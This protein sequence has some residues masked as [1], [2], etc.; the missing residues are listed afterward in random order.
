MECNGGSACLRMSR[1]THRVWL[2][3]MD[4]H[5]KVICST[6]LSKLNWRLRR[7]RKYSRHIHLCTSL[8]QIEIKS[9]ICAPGHCGCTLRVNHTGMVPATKS[10]LRSTRDMQYANHHN[11]RRQ[12]TLFYELNS[13]R[14]ISD[15]ITTWQIFAWVNS[16]LAKLNWKTLARM[17]N[18]I[19]ELWIVIESPTAAPIAAD[20]W[21]LCW[22]REMSRC[23]ISICFCFACLRWIVVRAPYSPYILPRFA[24]ISGDASA[25]HS[26][27]FS[28]WVKWI[29]D[30]VCKAANR[31]WNIIRMPRGISLNPGLG[32]MTQSSFNTSR[33]R[34][35]WI[36]T[37]QFVFLNRRG[38]D[39]HFL[40]LLIFHS[41]TSHSQLP[42]CVTE[43]RSATPTT[44]QIKID[45]RTILTWIHFIFATSMH[46]FPHPF[47]F[48]LHLCPSIANSKCSPSF[49]DTAVPPSV[50]D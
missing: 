24:P 10:E 50:F 39:F 17:E 27:S 36:N 33:C 41:L 16:K 8:H 25:W 7:W 15:L 3:L 6:F 48:R 30:P 43:H 12:V 42:I 29:Q 34:W 32:E 18:D 31:I 14:Y 1:Q 19:F 49:R 21:R 20:L 28:I 2:V 5:F 11:A 37:L 46:A 22:G 40:D 35:A 26:Q 44:Q 47:P 23:A 45:L 9:I 13:S 38:M 4:F